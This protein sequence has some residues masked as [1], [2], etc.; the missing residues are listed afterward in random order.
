MPAPANTRLG[1]ETA[2][3]RGKH[4]PFEQWH[5]QPAEQWRDGVAQ[6]VAQQGE[7]SWSYQQHV[8]PQRRKVVA[9]E[10]HETCRFGLVVFGE[11]ESHERAPGMADDHG[12]FDAELAQGLVEQLGLLGGGPQASA[13]AVTVAETG[14][15]EDNH[16]MRLYQELGDATGGPVVSSYGVAVDQHD[17]AALALV[18]VMQPHTVDHEERTLGR[19]PALRPARYEVIGHSERGQSS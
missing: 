16:S 12:P 10:Q 19:V 3:G 4:R 9:G 1:S 14:A 2:P 13:R 8:R 15:V 18:A 5:L 11:R 6:H 17:R 7:C